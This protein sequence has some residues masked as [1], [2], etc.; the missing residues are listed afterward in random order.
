MSRI[1]I[2]PSLLAA[3]FAR[4]GEEVA[5][6]ESSVD[7]LHLDVMDGH[8]VPNLS[9]GIPVIAA[10]REQSSLYFDCH[11]MTTNPDAFLPELAEAGVDLVTMHIEAIPDPTVAFRRA[12][13]E[14]L[15]VGLVINPGTPVAA[16]EPFLELVDVVLVMSVEP[17]FG[18]QRLIAEALGK[19]EKL[20]ETVEN[21]GFA[22]DIEIDGGI[23]LEN[24]GRAAEAGA[25]V[26]V[27]GTAIFGAENPVDAVRELR[28][29]IEKN[30]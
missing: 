27:S 9:F 17:G 16:V 23:T 11:L 13:A 20:R 24:I 7:W 15:D 26:F 6:V 10:L 5:R 19:V 30:D 1:K 25:H 4:L 14:G 18:G 2:A 22:T 28:R 29:T 8:F 3:D 21:S 12:R